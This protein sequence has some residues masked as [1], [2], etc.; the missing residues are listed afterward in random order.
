MKELE[1]DKDFA[2]VVNAL[3]KGDKDFTLTKKGK[4]KEKRVADFEV[5]G[6]LK[7]SSFWNVCWA[8]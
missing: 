2:E 4:H 3:R 5:N 7:M 6:D 1:E 8:I